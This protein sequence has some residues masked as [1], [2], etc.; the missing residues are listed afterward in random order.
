MKEYTSITDEDVLEVKRHIKNTIFAET[1][2]EYINKEIEKLTKR[3][4]EISGKLAC[5]DVMFEKIDLVIKN[6]K[7]DLVRLFEHS[8][9]MDVYMSQLD[10]EEGRILNQSCKKYTS[11]EI[12]AYKNGM[13]RATFF[14]IKKKAMENLAVLMKEDGC[15]YDEYLTI[16]TGGNEKCM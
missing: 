16:K 1:S 6:R 10:E 4:A 3:K 11:C 12:I 14:R 5:N 15:L 2:I 9:A 7:E 8:L 13:S